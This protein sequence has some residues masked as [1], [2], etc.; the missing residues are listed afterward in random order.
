[1]RIFIKTY[2]N[3][4]NIVLDLTSSD[5]QTALACNNLNRNYIG[6]DLDP[7]MIELSKKRLEEHIKDKTLKKDIV[8]I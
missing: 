6:F 8:E 3:E 7:E 5:G 1:M 2:T 4:N